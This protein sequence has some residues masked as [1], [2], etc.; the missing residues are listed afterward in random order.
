MADVTK[1]IEL[2]FSAQD[3][4]TGGVNNVT[5][6][7]MGLRNASDAATKAQMGL[8]EKMHHLGGAAR[9]VI[10]AVRTVAGGIQKI[11]GLNA[12]WQEGQIR[13][14]GQLKAMDLVPT[15]EAGKAA[16]KDTYEYMEKVAGPLP[17]ELEDYLSVFEKGLAGFARAGY[18]N[19]QDVAQRSSAYTAVA[20]SAGIDSQQAGMDLFRILN[21]QAGAD[22]RTWTTLLPVLEKAG[23][24]GQDAAKTWN[25]MDAAAR[26][27]LLTKATGKYGDMIGASTDQA[28]AVGGALGSQFKALT[29]MFTKPIYD[30]A[31]K[32]MNTMSAKLEGVMD[33]AEGYANMAGEAIYEIVG[34]INAAF[35]ASVEWIKAAGGHL[36]KYL[37]RPLANIKA[38]ISDSVGAMADRLGGAGAAVGLGAM[39]Y[40]GPMAAMAVGAVGGAASNPEALGAMQASLLDTVGSFLRAFIAV[41][42]AAMVV[43]NAIGSGLMPV[44]EPV[45]GLFS[46]VA[47]VISDVVVSMSDTVMRFVDNLKPIFGAMMDSFG[48]LLATVRKVLGP[49]ITLLGGA[50]SG[51]FDFVVWTLTPIFK[52]VGILLTGLS[53]I[54]EAF[55][56]MFAFML[57]EQPKYERMSKGEYESQRHLHGMVR[58]AK[59]QFD[60]ADKLKALGVYG[61]GA[62]G[63]DSAEA[64]V[65]KAAAAKSPGGR[66]GATTFDFRGSRF[67][68]RQAF[69]DGFD[70]DRVAAAFTSDLAALGE[71]RVQSTF[72][73]LFSVP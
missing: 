66:G 41:G 17:G 36:D 27:E 30:I 65:K 68:V 31:L 7:M 50:V 38:M 16:A 32:G 6:S 23:N 4:A 3:R 20:I 45:I 24:L 19:L 5:R 14:A 21:G 26:I 9:T 34:G 33:Q 61:D 72:A 70:P 25:Q 67:D 73:P 44:L 60:L 18:T 55:I 48:K 37:S 15:F 2:I 58:F 39:A 11:I 43:G 52:A 1:L 53:E 51:L 57:P 13:I 8:I 63:V 62:A 71:R 46:D 40:G 64:L 47:S 69:A 56:G 28:S 12:A 42:E 10:T 54:L 22:V 49:T 29:R 35:A 59:V